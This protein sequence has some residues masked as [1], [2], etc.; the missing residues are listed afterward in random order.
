MRLVISATV[1][2]SIVTLYAGPSWA[3]TKAAPKQF[4]GI[5]LVDP[6]NPRGL[7]TDISVRVDPANLILIDPVLR[8]EVKSIPYSTITGI[9]DTFS[10]TPP[11]SPEV[12]SKSTSTGA[13]SMPSY[14]GKEPRHWWTINAG[15]GSPTILRV[16]SKIYKDLKTAV[17]EHNVTIQD[18]DAKKKT[19]TK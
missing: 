1:L 14:L 4:G 6:Q 8:K 11:L 15:G 2:A 3:Q 10:I 13:G 7:E 9:D 5:K 12:I 16:S 18:V 17:A 19:K